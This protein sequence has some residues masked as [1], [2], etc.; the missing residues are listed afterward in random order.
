MRVLP[1]H[2]VCLIWTLI[3]DFPTHCA[4]N[5]DVVTNLQE[6]HCKIG[7]KRRTDPK[8]K[9]ASVD[10]IFTHDALLIRITQTPRI[11]AESQPEELNQSETHL[12]P[13][14]KKGYRICTGGSGHRTQ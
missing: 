2:T 7:C 9:L 1:L 6:N 5:I 10:T 4:S 14:P 11:T 13:S 3:I 8:S 12:P